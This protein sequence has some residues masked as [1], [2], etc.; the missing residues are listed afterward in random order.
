MPSGPMAAMPEPGA[1]LF[2]GAPPSK[3]NVIWAGC[4]G[5]PLVVAVPV[6]PTGAEPKIVA[7]PVA[8]T[9]WPANGVTSTK[10]TRPLLC[11][12][13]R[14]VPVSLVFNADTRPAKSVVAVFSVT[15]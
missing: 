11:W 8:V 9:A 7:A 10:R 1:R 15:G 3:F 13:C 5:V 2:T 6:A 4:S 12:A 14:G